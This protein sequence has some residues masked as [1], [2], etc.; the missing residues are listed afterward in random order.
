MGW[1]WPAACSAAGREWWTRNERTRTVPALPLEDVLRAAVLAL[2]CQRLAFAA[3]TLRAQ[4]W[5]DHLIAVEW[6][7]AQR[8]DRPLGMARR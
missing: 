5:S 3:A 6:G 2:V 8:Q 1:G 4:G 7:L